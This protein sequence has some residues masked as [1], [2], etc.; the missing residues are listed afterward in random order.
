MANASGPTRALFDG[1]FASLGKRL[2]HPRMAGLASLGGSIEGAYFLSRGLFLPQELPALIGTDMAR[3]GLAR[4]AGSPPGIGRADA[5]DVTAA[6]GLLESTC[7]LRNQL[8]RD[9]DWASMDHSLEL[10]TPLVDTRLLADLA[11]FVARF[12]RGAGKA[13]MAQSPRASLPA[14]I[15][16]R[17]KTGFG[18]PMAKWLSQAIVDAPGRRPDRKLHGKSW[19]RHWAAILM[20]DAM[21]CA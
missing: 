5:R 9:S 7:Y 16:S 3:D 13:L 6:V 18:V 15:A 2:M 14:A 1:F 20:A 17:P 4:L 12:R 10:R 21:S 8:L 19:A 11:P